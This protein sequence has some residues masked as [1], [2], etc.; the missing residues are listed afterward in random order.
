[1]R[2]N[3]REQRKQ[4][5][6]MKVKEILDAEGRRWNLEEIEDKVTLQEYD[7]ILAVPIPLEEK[8]DQQI[9]PFTKKGEYTVRSGY[10][11]SKLN[12]KKPK[13]NAASTSE[14][15]D[16][17]IWRK[18]WNVKAAPKVVNFLRKATLNILPV[19]NNL[20][21]RKIVSDP[22]C[23]ICGE[24][25]ETVEHCLLLCSWTMAIWFGCNLNY[26]VNRKDITTFDKWLTKILSMAGGDRESK[27]VTA[28]R[29][30]YTCWQIWKSRSSM[31]HGK[32]QVRIIE[33]INLAQILADE[34]WIKNVKKIV[35]FDDEEN[36][37]KDDIR[38][39]KNKGK[40]DGKVVRSEEGF[41]ETLEDAGV[42][43]GKGG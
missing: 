41:I 39:D 42:V 18:I 26:K 2:L 40:N 20:H 33:V 21:K 8:E 9:W 4:D 24:E 28:T 36:A 30:A 25:A 32:E 37:L 12:E 15:I 5:D 19:W 22:I 6:G 1:M 11:N 17:D 13:G 43:K 14:S 7:A 3:G 34:W 29:I 31:I 35:S 16:N 27:E 10:H 38:N 23:R